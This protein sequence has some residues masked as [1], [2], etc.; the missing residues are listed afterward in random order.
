MFLQVLAYGVILFSI[1]AGMQSVLA[2]NTA[3]WRTHRV[4]RLLDTQI[5]AAQ[6][7]LRVALASRVQVVGPDGPFALNATTPIAPICPTPSAS[8]DGAPPPAPCPF[9]ASMQA[10]VLDDTK[11]SA[12]ASPSSTSTDV[13]AN[14]LQTASFVDEQRVSALVKVTLYSADGSTQVAEREELVT[15]RTFNAA[16]YVVIT[17]VADLSGSAGLPSEG[18]TAGCDPLNTQS[19]SSGTPSQVPDD[20]R[21][22]ALQ[23]VK[24]DDGSCLPA[25]GSDSFASPQWQNSNQT[26]QNGWRQ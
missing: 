7:N 15:A 2:T 21:I 1:I 10:T 17:G 25:P 14:N 9:Q 19:C 22:H 16:P 11:Q 24:Q 23:C 13:V 4:D 8:S 5:G 26:S 18:D 20:T 6:E 12:N 3:T